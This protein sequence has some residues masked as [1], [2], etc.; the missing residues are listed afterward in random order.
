MLSKF[1]KEDHIWLQSNINLYKA[2]E[3]VKMQEKMVETRSCKHARALTQNKNCG[4]CTK[5]K[6]TVVHILAGCTPLAGGEYLMRHNKALKVDWKKGALLEGNGKKLVC[7]FK[8]KMRKMTIVSRPNHIL[9]NE[10]D[11][12]IWVIDMACPMGKT[13]EE[14]GTKRVVNTNSCCS[15]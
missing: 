10:L 15:K 7:D 6:E 13:I 3:I 8:F 1:E 5:Y 11:K 4:V 12:K 9:E 14:T 2:S